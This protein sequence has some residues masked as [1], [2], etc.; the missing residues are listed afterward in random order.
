MS[1]LDATL[2]VIYQDS[3]GEYTSFSNSS[4]PLALS[5]TS[6]EH[7]ERGRRRRRCLG[8]SALV[9]LLPHGS[10]RHVRESCSVNE[11]KTSALK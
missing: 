4:P 9:P 11:K 2:R 3:F 10:G 6:E 7:E 5:R 8:L 1:S